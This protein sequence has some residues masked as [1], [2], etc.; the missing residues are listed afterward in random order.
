MRIVEIL[1]EDIEQLPQ[2]IMQHCQPFLQAI[3]YEINDFRL[4][5]G[6]RQHDHGTLIMPGVWKYDV[7]KHR[8]PKDMPLELHDVIDSYFYRKTGIHFRSNATFATSNT[9]EIM[10]YGTGYRFFP[11]GEFSFCWSPK[12][13]DLFKEY[14]DL[15]SKAL[16]DRNH[17]FDETRV[18]AWLD[19]LWYSTSDLKGAINSGHEIMFNCS[20]YIVIDPFKSDFYNSWI[21]VSK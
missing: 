21:Q 9:A 5:R 1:T 7:M 4:H 16:L 19:E 18:F 14:E 12:V 15:P 6:M 11:I 13:V 3:D 20:S 8:R 2:F 17:E 10:D